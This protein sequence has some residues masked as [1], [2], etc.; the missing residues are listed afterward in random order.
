MTREYKLILLLTYSMAAIFAFTILR[1]VAFFS[2]RLNVEAED[3]FIATRIFL[4]GPVLILLG[5][6][7]LIKFKNT[8]HQVFGILFALGGIVWVILVVRAFF[9]E[10][11]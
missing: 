4:S 1:Y 6:F 3:R 10:A 7:L 2:L 5:A 8:A 11:A 9:L